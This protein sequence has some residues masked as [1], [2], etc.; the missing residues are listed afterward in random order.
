MTMPTFDILIL[1]R[2]SGKTAR[3][4]YQAI[5]YLLAQKNVCYCVPCGCFLP[6][7][8]KLF[9]VVDPA[10]TNT[11]LYIT[12]IK[13]IATDLKRTP[14]DVFIF[15]ELLLDTNIE[16]RNKIFD[17]VTTCY[18]DSHIIVYSSAVDKFTL[19]YLQLNEER[20]C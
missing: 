14:I 2:Q 16:L 1:P 11:H 20:K 8:R 19:K 17:D 13:T 3:C 7:I 12:T 6:Q 18:P 10:I 15:D 5:V 9:S 4:F